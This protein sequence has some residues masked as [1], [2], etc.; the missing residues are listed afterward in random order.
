MASINQSIHQMMAL[1]ELAHK[2]TLIHRLAPLVKLVVTTLYV[3]MVISYQPTQLNGLLLYAS[4]PV[5][6]MIIGEIPFQPLAV[7]CLLALP[8]ALFAGISN[9]VLSRDILLQIGAVGITEGMITF[10][11]LLLKTVLTVMAVL[12][13]VSTTP[14]NDLIYALM[15]LRVPSVLIVQFMMTY[16]Y[17]GLLGEEAS[18]MSHAY[19]LRAPKEKGIKF[20]DIGPFMGQLILRS[21]DRADRI[22]HAMQCRGFDGKLNL[23][24]KRRLKSM[25]WAAMIGVSLVIILLRYI[26]WR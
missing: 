1:E 25:D 2:D 6:F 5:F 24:K 13:L 22:Y 8:F 12:L 23:S 16:R 19:L 18:R 7:R 4:F 26:K 9:L 3:I 10:T 17:L 11:S 15:S 14:M 21:F 20:K